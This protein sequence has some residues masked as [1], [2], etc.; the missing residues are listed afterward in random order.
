MN[1]ATELG[2]ISWLTLPFCSNLKG[3][4]MSLFDFMEAG[5]K[6]NQ[7]YIGSTPRIQ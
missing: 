4:I 1:E 2:L 3:K 7:F 6:V 5:Q